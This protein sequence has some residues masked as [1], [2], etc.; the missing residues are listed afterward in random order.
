MFESLAGKL[1]SRR[2]VKR[3]LTKGCQFNQYNV[4]KISCFYTNARSL[5]N[6]FVELRAFMSVKSGKTRYNFCNREMGRC[7]CTE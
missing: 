6:K 5:N 3:P 4:N 1:N 7:F 2:C